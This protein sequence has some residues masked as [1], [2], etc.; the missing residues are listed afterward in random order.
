MFHEFAAV[1]LIY[2]PGDKKPPRVLPDGF[3]VRVYGADY[4]LQ[5]HIPLL[6]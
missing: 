6:G 1:P 3:F 5:G 2:Q 4:P